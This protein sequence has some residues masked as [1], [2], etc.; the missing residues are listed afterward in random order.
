[1]KKL[2]R[3]RSKIMCVSKTEVTKKCSIYIGKQIRRVHLQCR[4]RKEKRQ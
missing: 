3:V 1:M 4:R 2:E